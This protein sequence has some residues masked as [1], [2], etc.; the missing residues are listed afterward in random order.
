MILALHLIEITLWAGVY[1]SQ[2]WLPNWE[3][4]FYFSATSYSTTG[5]GDIVLPRAWRLTG[6]MESV[7]G[8]LLM[9]WSAGF[10]FAI[11]HRLFEIRI[12]LWQREKDGA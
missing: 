12:R 1:V 11:V 7:T 10:F 8:V 2:H 4:S 3:S 6:V 5:Y 9:G